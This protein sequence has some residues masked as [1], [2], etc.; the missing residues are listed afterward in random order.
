[1]KIDTIKILRRLNE[2]Q[3]RFLDLKKDACMCTTSASL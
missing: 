3:L 1:M 2:G